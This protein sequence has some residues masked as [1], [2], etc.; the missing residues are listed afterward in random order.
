VPPDKEEASQA[1]RQLHFLA[2]RNQN[3]V[4]TLLHVR[5]S[6]W[7]TVPNGVARPGICCTAAGLSRLK[8]LKTSAYTFSL[9]SR[10]LNCFV[11]R[12]SIFTNGGATKWFRPLVQSTPLKGLSHLRLSPC[13]KRKP[14]SESRFAHEKSPTRRS[15]KEAGACSG[16][17]VS[18]QKR[19]PTVPYPDRDRCRKF[20]PEER[21]SQTHLDPLNRKQKR[22]GHSSCLSLN[23]SQ[24]ERR[25]QNL[26]VG[27]V[28]K[29]G[30]ATPAV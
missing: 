18:D 12:M 20:P 1:G 30:L 2:F 13:S 28:T 17:G 22:R 9:R 14:S 21:S 27:P 4:P 15:P 24:S 26:C 19:D 11:T 10:K 5:G 16:P 3:E 23:Q 7:R 8:R 25:Q 6:T 29:M